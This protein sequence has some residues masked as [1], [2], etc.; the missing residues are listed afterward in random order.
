M[1]AYKT[2][3]IGPTQHKT[4]KPRYTRLRNMILMAMGFV[5]LCVGIAWFQGQM[6]LIKTPWVLPGIMIFTLA[7]FIPFGLRQETV[8]N[9]MITLQRHSKT[10]EANKREVK[11]SIWNLFRTKSRKKTFRVTYTF[12]DHH[13]KGHSVKGTYRIS[14]KD[15]IPETATVVYNPFQISES[16]VLIGEPHEFM[17]VK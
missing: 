6:A 10:A 13:G 9:R 14:R 17:W 12:D 4:V 11:S 7:I 5:L 2:Y 1:K 15:L 8:N 3:Y 16:L